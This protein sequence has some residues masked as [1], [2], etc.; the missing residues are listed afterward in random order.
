MAL[1]DEIQ[2][3]IARGIVPAQ[4]RVGDLTTRPAGP[5]RFFVGDADY[6]RN[7]INS[8]PGNL[9]ISPDGTDPGDYVKR[10]Q[11]PRF[12]KIG[13][14]LF[15]LIL[16]HRHQGP[17]PPN[18][19]GL[20]CDEGED[21]GLI[22]DGGDDLTIEVPA[23]ARVA[24]ASGLD[25]AAIIVETLAQRPFQ[26]Y[27]R[28]G[29]CWHPTGPGH[30]WAERLAAYRWPTL[31]DGWEANDRRI[32]GFVA[33]GKVL[34]RRWNP[35]DP[36][37]Q[38]DLEALFRDVSVWGGV[39]KP[40]VSAAVL[41]S[42]VDTALRE[43]DAGHLPS[44]AIN[45]AWTKLYA[46]LRP[47]T[48]IIFDSRVATA[49]TSILDPH[50]EELHGS[51]AW[52]PYAHLGTVGGRGGTRPRRLAHRWPVGYQRWDSQLAANRLGIA[53]RDELNRRTGPLY[54]KAD[55]SQ[56]TLREVEAVLFMEGY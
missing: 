55:G 43:I 45:S 41:A 30:G 32:N 34:G 49:L 46:V 20:N 39:R 48:V 50:M 22:G 35:N 9:S 56:W 47:D 52:A 31:T 24:L 12:Y 15:E 17:M 37:F 51:A 19:A 3:D 54:S 18:V 25:P 7:A 53:V 33:K 28:R 13:R 4:F 6:A 42:T 16:D 36:A 14:G 44:S 29:R 5:A 10:G 1:A 26:F 27:S 40:R 38:A 23:P 21:E 11:T 8:I 2:L